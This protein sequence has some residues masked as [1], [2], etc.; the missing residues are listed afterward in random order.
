LRWIV[1]KAS[2]VFNT[3]VDR[4]LAGTGKSLTD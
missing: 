2:A 1:S 3:H 4:E